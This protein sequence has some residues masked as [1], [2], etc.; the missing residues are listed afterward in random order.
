MNVKWLFPNW[1]IDFLIER[2]KKDPGP[3]MRG[4]LKR[5]FLFRSNHL[6]VTIHQIKRADPG[7]VQ[8][9]KHNH[10]YHFISIVLRGKYEERLIRDNKEEFIV[11]EEGNVCIRTRSNRH[12]ISPLSKEV[13]TLFFRIGDP[14]GEWGRYDKDGNYFSMKGD[15]VVNV[16][17]N[18]NFK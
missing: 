14:S 6:S 17:G 13:W 18:A 1:L 11:R 16:K 3:H 2:A 7:G 10:P 15:T 5:Y 9:F 4:F 8:G 12:A